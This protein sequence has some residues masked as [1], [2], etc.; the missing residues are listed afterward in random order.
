MRGDSLLQPLRHNACGVLRVRPA[1]IRH[2]RTPLTRVH[3]PRPPT[4]GG[5]VAGAEDE[6]TLTELH[7]RGYEVG[8][9]DRDGRALPNEC[10]SIRANSY[11]VDVGSIR[12]GAE[13]EPGTGERCARLRPGGIEPDGLILRGQDAS[14]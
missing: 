6:P 3:D 8:P 1:R 10:H 13:R 5:P 12:R 2:N 7:L 14:P 11:S 4:R 9:R